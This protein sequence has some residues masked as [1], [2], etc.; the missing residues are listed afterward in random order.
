M[1]LMLI[2]GAVALTAV[3]AVVW[4]F[5]FSSRAKARRTLSGT[6]R[7]PIAEVRDGMVIKL[8]GK[9]RLDD[10]AKPLIAPLSKRPCAHFGLKIERRES[11]GNTSYWKTIVN[12]SESQPFWL[13][14]PS[15]RALIEAIV[16]N[17]VLNLDAHRTS[18]TFNEATPDLDA[19]LARHG[20]SSRGWVFNKNIRY[21]EGVLEAGEIVAVVGLC[22]LETD[23]DP[24]AEGG[25]YRERPMR[26]VVRATDQGELLITDELH[27]LR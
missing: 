27:L 16:P 23:P 20:H 12:E 8:V 22:K 3:G 17:V 25:G 5:N 26:L 1:E 24:Q 4:H 9:L 2:F 14:D 6:P 18:G 7:V 11:T 19:L 15:G 13:V 21:T 10:D